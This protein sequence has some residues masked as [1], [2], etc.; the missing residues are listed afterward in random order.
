LPEQQASG[1]SVR[2]FCRARRLPP[3]TFYKLRARLAAEHER[4]AFVELRATERIDSPA[5]AAIELALANGGRVLVRPGFEPQ[6]LRAL[7]GVL[8]GRAGPP[9]RV[10]NVVAPLHLFRWISEVGPDRHVERG[11][12]LQAA[13]A[14]RRAYR[15]YVADG[16][17]WRATI[18]ESDRHA[19]SR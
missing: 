11:F 19:A 1:R 6:T 10:Q 4:P 7:L 3:T 2:A 9:E 12:E 18:R 16:R 14:R 15:T 8:D 5:E 17:V 13:T